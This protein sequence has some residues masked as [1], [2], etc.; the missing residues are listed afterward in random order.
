LRNI[1]QK[2]EILYT[3]GTPLQELLLKPRVAIVGSR[4]ITPYGKHVT[5]TLAGKLAEHGVVIISGLALGVDACAHQAALESGGRCIAVLPCPLDNIV[6]TTNRRLAQAILDGGGTLVSE[7]APGAEIFKHNFVE[8][9]RLMSGLADAVLITEAAE[10]SGTLHTADFA[11]DQSKEVLAVPGNITSTNS[12]GANKIIGSGRAVMV[13]SYKD[14][15]YALK[16]TDKQ[17]AQTELFGRNPQ[18][19]IILDLVQAGVSD[20]EQLRV[21]SKLDTSKFNQVLSMLE[22]R[23]KIRPLGANHWG[24]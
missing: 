4:T 14:V 21:G 16:I 18:E 24:V 6:P 5:S 9:N 3:I 13:N 10:G 1:A 8:R 12:Q 17:I 15:L 19:Q 7:Y 20:G 11:L 22:I 23:G 2:P